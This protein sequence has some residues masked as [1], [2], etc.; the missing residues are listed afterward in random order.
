MKLLTRDINKLINEEFEKLNLASDNDVDLRQLQKK[1]TKRLRETDLNNYADDIVAE[2]ITLWAHAKTG[3]YP[4]I[5]QMLL[6]GFNID[7]LSSKGFR[8][9]QHHFVTL[10]KANFDQLTYRFMNQFDHANAAM[11]SAALTKAVMDSEIGKIMKAHRKLSVA[12]AEARWR[13]Q[14]DEHNNNNNDGKDRT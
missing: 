6:E 4:P 3:D 1:V 8:F 5:E 11:Q 12:K 14:I 13:K 7:E 2:R 10:D 9:E